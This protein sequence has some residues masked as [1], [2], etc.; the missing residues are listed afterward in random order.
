M[1]SLWCA[2]PLLGIGWRFPSKWHNRVGVFLS[3]TTERRHVGKMAAV[4]IHN[5]LSFGLLDWR[6]YLFLESVSGQKAAASGQVFFTYGV[7]SC[8]SSL[9]HHSSFFSI[10]QN[11]YC[12]PVLATLTYSRKT[13][14]D[15]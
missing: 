5:N 10:A 7:D 4:E 8:L 1:K 9:R 12:Y 11:A 15:L 13:I 2:F 14:I 3:L 6:I